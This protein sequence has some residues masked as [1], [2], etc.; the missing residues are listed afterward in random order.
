MTQRPF[1]WAIAGYGKV[2]AGGHHHGILR[3]RDVLVGFTSSD[4]GI[5]VG[6]ATHVK[7]NWGTIG[8]KFD[9]STMVVSK[10]PDDKWLKV[11]RGKAEAVIVSVPTRAHREVVERVLAAGFDCLVE[12]P[13]AM[14]AAEG[15]ELVAIAGRLG[16]KLL[17]AQ[18]LPAFQEFDI[19]RRKIAEKGLK[20]LTSLSMHRWVPWK[21][22]TD[23]DE[24]AVGTGYFAD[25]AVHDA[26]FIASLRGDPMVK[27]MIPT[28]EHGKVQR[29]SVDFELLE[30]RNAVVSIDVG[31]TRGS[32][33]FQHGFR[34][35]WNDGQTL[36]LKG[37]VLSSGEDPLTLPPQTPADIFGDELKLAANCF[38]DGPPEYLDANSACQAL[39][40]V[41]RVTAAK[42][43]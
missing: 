2:A 20:T 30:A 35:E 4:V 23:K 5:L 29:A 12:K 33:E 26:H 17:V 21:N 31:A 11:L 27:S 16:R 34:A 6:D 38:R 32:K 10:R 42:P 36:S 37:G 14:T 1:A 43:S 41:E 13:I 9:A 22:V 40:L 7:F 3:N 25:L 18:V 28:T 24:I 39:E 19:L 15:R 8:L